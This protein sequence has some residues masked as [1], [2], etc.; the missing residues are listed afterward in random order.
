MKRTFTVKTLVLSLAAAG[1]VTLPAQRALANPQ[2]GQVVAGSATIA[3]ETASK[4]GITQTSQKAIIDWRSFSI[5][6]NEHTQ[7][8]QPSASAVVLNRVTGQDPSAILGRMSANGQVFL[9]N[10][11]GIYFGKSAQIDVA[12]LVASTHNIRNED[13]LAGRYQFTIPGKPG[14]AV[15]NEGTLRIADT[16]IAAFVA[17]SAANHGVIVAKLGKI[18]LASANGFTLDFTGDQLLTFMVGDNV[19]QTAFDID[20]KQLTS[21]VENSGTIEA[22]GGYVLLS[23]KA[24]E[25]AV[26]S[27]INQSGSIEATSVG[28]QNGE[29][30]LTANNGTVE[31]SGTLD[32]SAP[33]SGNGGKITMTNDTGTLIT[34]GLLD[35]SSANGVGGNI[36]LSGTRIGMG[37]KTYADGVHGGRIEVTA[38]GTLSLADRVSATGS[39]GSGGQI[40]Y[41]AGSLIETSTGIN[42]VSGASGGQIT[43]GISGSAISS[44]N[45]LAKGEKA[46]GGRIDFTG[47]TVRLLSA[48]L[49]ARGVNQGG[50]VRVG[51]AFQGGKTPDIAQAY[52][53]SFVGRWL[54]VTTLSNAR[55]TFINDGAKIDVSST[56]GIGG[57]AVIWSNSETTQL[58]A[59]NA[60][61]ATAGGAVEISS[62][63]NLRRASLINVETGVGGFLLLDPK[64]IVIGNFATVSDWSYQAILGKGYLSGKNIDSSGVE[65]GDVFGDAV[66]LNAAGDRLAVGARND[67]GSGNSVGGSGAV[68]LFSFTDGSFLGGS[69]QGTIGKGYSGGKNIDVSSL[70]SMDQFG[71]S[72]ALNAAG[73]IL[74]VGAYGDDGGGNAVAESGAVRL[75]SFTDSNFTSGSLQATIGKGYTG[76]KNIDV[77]GL[78]TNYLF[79]RSVAVNA[80]GDRLAVGTYNDAIGGAV[81]LFSFSD[82]NFSSGALEATMGSGYAGGKNINVTSLDAGDNFGNSVALSASGD[83]LAV[84]AIRDDGSGN[85]VSDSGAVYL[86]SFTDTYFTG[87]TLLA[88]VGKGYTGGKNVDVSSLEAS[89]YFGTGVAFNSTGT[90]LA[91]GAYAD[92]GSGNVATDSGS[93]YLFSFTDG[94][95]TSGSLQGTIGKGYT[96]GK[97][98]DVASLEAN[99]HLGASVALNATGDR[100]AAGAN[101]DSGSGNIAAAAGAMH[102]FSFT[103]TT[104]SG[105]ARVGTIGKGYSGIGNV[106]VADVEAADIF[107]V[108]V[109]LNA[110]GNRLAVGAGGDGGSGNV[111]SN[112]GAV[113]LFSF[114]DTS[115]SGGALQGTIGKGYTGGKNVNVGS[116]ESTDYFGNSVALNAVGDRLAVGSYNDGGAGN[117]AAGS[118][119]AYLFSFSDAAFSGGAL[120]ATLGKGYTG[121]KNV[122][123]TNVDAGDFF[124]YSVALNAAGD[125]L[126]VGAYQDGGSGNVASQSGAAYL[127]SFS[128]TTFSGGTLQATLGKGYTGGKN[129]DMASVETN[130]L[131]GSAVSL[132]ATGNRL[133]VGAARDAGSGNVASQSGAAYLFSFSDTAFSGG[134]LQATVGKGYTGGKNF[135]VAGLEANDQFG[136]AIALNATGD[137]LAIGAPYESGVDNLVAGSGAVRLFSFSDTSFTGGML[138]ATFG[139]G[140]T[141]GMNVDV[142]SL[143]ANDNFGQS[144]ALNAVGDRL[145]VGAI[146]DDGSGNGTAQ[147]GAVRLFASAGVISNTFADNP[148]ST[149]NLSAT[150]LSNQLSSGTNVA[151]AANNDIT[152]NSAITVNNPSGNG[153]NFTMAA[154]RSILVNANITTDNGNLNFIANETNANGV[155]DAYRDI[156]AASITNN[157]TLHAGTGTI[158]YTIRS[159]NATGRS[160][161]KESSGTLSAGTT[162]AANTVV[163]VPTTFTTAQQTWLAAHPNPTISDLLVAVGSGL[164]VNGT[165]DPVWTSLYVNGQATSEQILANSLQATYNSYKTATAL[166]ILDGLRSGNLQVVSALWQALGVSNAANRDAALQQYNC[167]ITPSNCST[168]T[169][170]L[171]VAQKENPLPDDGGANP[172]LVPE[173]Q[174]GDSDFLIDWFANP[175]NKYIYDNITK[176]TA[177]LQEIFGRTNV[178]LREMTIS[179]LDS[180]LT[181]LR[182]RLIKAKAENF[183]IEDIDNL[184]MSLS[185]VAGAKG[186]QTKALNA[187]IEDAE[188][189]SMAQ[190]GL[191]AGAKLIEHASMLVDMGVALDK[192]I[193][194]QLTI[195]DYEQ[196]VTGAG[197]AALTKLLPSEQVATKVLGKVML[198]ASAMQLGVVL[199]EMSE[200]VQVT[201]LVKQAG[202]RTKFQ[203]KQ[204]D[205]FVNAVYELGKSGESWEEVSGKLTSAY[206]SIIQTGS[207]V[208]EIETMESPAARLTIA[209]SGNAFLANQTKQAI[210]DS[211]NLVG[212]LTMDQVKARFELGKQVYSSKI[213]LGQ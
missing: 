126:A 17:P 61:G 212:S 99:D 48:Q 50:L 209:L 117:V 158:S 63:A 176:D 170:N 56:Q 108:A 195:S 34:S 71:A 211:I 74:A 52:Y 55:A 57:T 47:D 143:E 66:A 136:R 78:G 159:A 14:A 180:S 207:M 160:G 25:N 73:N 4:I 32:A 105:G 51:G 7:F 165:N 114:T 5:G 192:A 100:L 42:D 135:D 153:G 177:I 76:G 157:A 30:V 20:G 33:V 49:D 163:N 11:N 75:F 107:G 44:G 124:A 58:G 1:I 109:A 41:H 147:S 200:G 98:I 130:D 97:N 112:S 128:D 95:F 46:Q 194:G 116:L 141:G 12:G 118:G 2:G 201:D 72:V 206:F 115:F 140:Y 199:G 185:K 179:E 210:L 148:S 142:T 104:F 178:Q 173:T 205:D 82:T 65:A 187:M 27:V 16:G 184:R 22:Q 84:G 132:N 13:F 145:A 21:F 131:F 92:D 174:K 43:V 122:D 54:D 8:Y 9:V 149:V 37:A 198:G 94:N 64:N 133:A 197:S 29:I 172:E 40:L 91:V 18:A 24:A 181:T 10:P 156:G 103:D 154:G 36:T 102:L 3:Q 113:H 125:R 6:A 182:A 85:G 89:D 150:D 139:K 120:Q 119:A 69:L 213:I 196:L 19:A 167:E 193:R 171:P 146:Y 129:V 204:V 110:S 90:R 88:T 189:L 62:A 175:T 169:P 191:S 144:V 77:A 96:G 93:V 45:Y 186:G 26:H 59:I 39:S 183:S 137:L 70:E 162:N 190:K 60:N 83:R 106:D 164:F 28:Q 203:V 86:Y 123:V 67:G 208:R 81:R 53:H 161:G 35:A 31:V 87:G 38:Q 155:L 121:G 168:R 79:G 188:L 152:V 15:I 151:L 134:T 166:G 23:A 111:A 80:A 138:L 68:H 127:F 202:E 101:A